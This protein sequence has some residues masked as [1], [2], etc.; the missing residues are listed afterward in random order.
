MKHRPGAIRPDIRDA[1]SAWKRS[2]LE[3]EIILGARRLLRPRYDVYLG[4]TGLLLKYQSNPI[5]VTP[6]ARGT[7]P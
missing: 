1:H 7:A 6:I 4:F 5:I 2:G 3:Y